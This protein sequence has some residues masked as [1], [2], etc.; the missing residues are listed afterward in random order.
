MIKKLTHKSVPVPGNLLIESGGWI[1]LVLSRYVVMWARQC[2]TT[3]DTPDDES[4]KDER[5][6]WFSTWD[7]ALDDR[8]VK[9]VT[10][11]HKKQKCR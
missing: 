4:N 6:D 9:L 5:D 10:D 1:G 3:L 11:V 7:S 8:T 2:H